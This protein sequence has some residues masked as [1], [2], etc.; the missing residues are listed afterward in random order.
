MTGEKT[1]NGRK[2]QVWKPGNLLYPVPAVLIT[3]SDGEGHDNLFTAA[4]TGTVCSDPAMVSVSVRKSRYSYGMLVRSREFII[5]LTTEALVRAADYCGVRSGR[6]EDK[7]ATMHLTKVPGTAVGV[8]AILE[9]PVNIECRVT[10]ILE[11][12]SHDLF[13]AR[14][15]AVTVAE[16]LLDASGRLNLEKAGLAAYSHG[17]YYALGRRLGSFGFS[18]RK[19]EAG[20]QE[21]GNQEKEEN[22]KKKEKEVNIKKK[23]KE[24]DVKK[25]EKE[26]DVNKEEKKEKGKNAKRKEK[27]II[28]KKTEKDN[29]NRGKR[30]RPGSAGRIRPEG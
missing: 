13:L 3:V 8:P 25:K 24:R 18:V 2:K 16:T 6:E 14:V 29:Q 10:Q 7:F 12:G 27:E 19:K 17:N 5:N 20:R 15:E 23:E 21:K 28:V 4:W 26:K 11:L 9:S 1:G 22:V 30:Q